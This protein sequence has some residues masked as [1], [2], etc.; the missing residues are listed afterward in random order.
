[1]S[2]I[3]RNLAEGVAVSGEKSCAKVVLGLVRFSYLEND[4]PSEHFGSERG[5]GST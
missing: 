5:R 3:G 1:M 4:K 2:S